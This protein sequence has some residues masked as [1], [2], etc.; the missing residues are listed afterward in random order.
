MPK[1]IFK[2]TFSFCTVLQ[3]QSFY[4]HGNA[5]IKKKKKEERNIKRQICK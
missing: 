1:G 4:C 2:T 5:K 3:N